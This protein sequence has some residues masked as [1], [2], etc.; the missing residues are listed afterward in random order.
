MAGEGVEDLVV[1]L[2][3]SLDISNMEQGIKLVGT[4]LVNKTLNKWGVRNILRSSWQRWGEIEIKWVKENT[5]VIK[6]NDE[7]TAAK[8]INQVPWA[9]MKQNFSVKRWPLELALE[10]I[11]MQRISFWIQ[12]RGVPP[13]LSSEANIRRLA[14]KIGKVQSVEDP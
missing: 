14:S 3:K 4:A 7:S 9:V 6:V 5:F 2:E 12:I 10:E 11:D 1:H 8:I 13:F